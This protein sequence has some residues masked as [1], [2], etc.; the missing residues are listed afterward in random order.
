MRGLVLD[1]DVMGLEMRLP[2][3]QVFG[4]ALERN[5]FLASAWGL[6]LVHG[7]LFEHQDGLPYA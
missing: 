5:K 2:S 7:R 1:G 3:R 6:R 4:G